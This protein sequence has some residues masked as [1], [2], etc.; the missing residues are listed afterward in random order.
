[1]GPAHDTALG[2]HNALSRIFRSANHADKLDVLKSHPDLAGKLT[3][4]KYLTKESFKEQTGAGLN[5]LTEQ[6][7]KDFEAL[8]YQYTSKNRFPFIIAV[9]DQT[10]TSILSSFRQ[11]INNDTLAEFEIACSEVEKIALL[12][13]KEILS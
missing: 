9:R 6:E 11:R 12:R 3:K 10:K 5:S 13:I 7:L 4:D 1:M 8:N 2:I